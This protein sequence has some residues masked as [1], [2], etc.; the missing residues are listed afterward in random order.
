MEQ[1]LKKHIPGLKATA[2]VDP[3]GCGDAWRAGL[4]WGLE[5]GRSLEQCVQ[6]GNRMGALKIAARGPQNY[7][8]DFD[9]TAL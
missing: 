4:L 8:L 6:L 2:V 7:E 9:P 3:T 5:N 1:G